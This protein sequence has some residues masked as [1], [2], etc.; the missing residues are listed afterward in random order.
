VFESPT[1]FGFKKEKQHFIQSVVYNAAEGM[2]ISEILKAKVK[3]LESYNQPTG[4]LKASNF[5]PILHFMLSGQGKSNAL[6]RGIQCA[7]N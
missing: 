7:I 5:R 1:S 2:K 4:S 6:I 3:N